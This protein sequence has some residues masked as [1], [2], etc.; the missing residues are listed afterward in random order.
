[1][2]IRI[3][4][5]KA[6]EKGGKERSVCSGTWFD[7]IKRGGVVLDPLNLVREKKSFVHEHFSSVDPCSRE[8]HSSIATTKADSPKEMENVKSHHP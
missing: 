4:K 2:R 1:M 5:R 6:R 7:E 3:E 8:R